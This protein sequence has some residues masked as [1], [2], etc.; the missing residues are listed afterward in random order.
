[1]IARELANAMRRVV[2]VCEVASASGNCTCVASTGPKST[3]Q[4]IA[5]NRV[6]SNIIG[7]IQYAF[8]NQQSAR[9]DAL[10]AQNMGKKAVPAEK[11]STK[12]EPVTVQVTAEEADDKQKYRVKKGAKKKKRN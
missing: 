2:V 10:E 1:M 5:G 11:M 7:I 6:I 4:Q 9:R 12:T 8:L 3:L